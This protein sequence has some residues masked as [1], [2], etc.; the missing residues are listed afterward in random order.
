MAIVYIVSIKLS[1][2]GEFQEVHILQDT[3]PQSLITEPKFR[4][5]Q[6]FNFVA[7]KINYCHYPGMA[8][9]FEEAFESRQL[10]H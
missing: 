7:T 8:I 10:F 1:T 6:H 9:C 2:L 4:K 5:L 3:K